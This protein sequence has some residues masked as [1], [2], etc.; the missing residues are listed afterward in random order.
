VLAVGAGIGPEPHLAFV[1][2]IE[3][4]RRWGVPAGAFRDATLR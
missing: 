3:S 2:E 4:V 1:V